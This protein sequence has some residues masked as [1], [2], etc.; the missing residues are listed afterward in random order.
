M[1]IWSM[2]FYVACTETPINIHA[3]YI[4]KILQTAASRLNLFLKIL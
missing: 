4:L 3:V 2:P 1:V